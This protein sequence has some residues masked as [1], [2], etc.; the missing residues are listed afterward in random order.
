M[1]M[2]TISFKMT[3]EEIAML[4]SEAKRANMSRS[5]YIRNNINNRAVSVIDKSK[6]FYQ[7]LIKLNEAIEATELKMGCGELTF[8]REAEAMLWQQLYL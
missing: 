6:E 8:I 4:D 7:C 2:K 3:D 1:E 5:D